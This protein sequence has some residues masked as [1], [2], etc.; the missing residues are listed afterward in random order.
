MAKGN[1]GRKRRLAMQITAEHVRME[2]AGNVHSPKRPDYFP[3]PV[4]PSHQPKLTKPRQE[5][6]QFSPRQQNQITQR[7]DQQL[8]HQNSVPE[9]GQEGESQWNY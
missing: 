8:R 3:K 7:D 9:D 6:T 2:P 5:G 4:V 1:E